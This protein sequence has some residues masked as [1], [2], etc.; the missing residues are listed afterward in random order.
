M[1][2]DK[3]VLIIVVVL[4]AVLLSFWVT[5]LLLAAFAVPLGWLAL[6]PATLAG[7][8]AWRVVQD[9]L[10]SSEDAYYDRIEK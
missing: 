2:L 5:T 4:G 3:L 10:A 6:L 1:K 8:I 9:R 7:Y